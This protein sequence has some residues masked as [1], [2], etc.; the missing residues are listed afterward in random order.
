MLIIMSTI[1][2]WKDVQAAK[3]LESHYSGLII[4]FKAIPYSYQRVFLRKLRFDVMEITGRINYIDFKLSRF[5]PSEYDPN[6]VVNIAPKEW[7][8]ESLKTLKDLKLLTRML[9][10]LYE[11]LRWI[12]TV[13]ERILHSHESYCTLLQHQYPIN[14]DK[15]GVLISM[16]HCEITNQISIKKNT[17]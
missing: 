8:W 9:E 3:Y 14:N 5:F 17:I 2:L 15:I 4:W 7:L 10:K 12:H 1:T 6:R 16:H 13:T 11:Y